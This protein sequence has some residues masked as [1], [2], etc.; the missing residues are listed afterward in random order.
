M[1]QN[2]QIIKFNPIGTKEW[3]N[4]IYDMY[5]NKQWEDNKECW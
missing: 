5:S 4:E 1:I 3:D 2:N